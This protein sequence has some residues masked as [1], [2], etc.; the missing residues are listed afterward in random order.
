M[1]IYGEKEERRVNVDIES[2]TLSSAGQGI[3]VFRQF[4]ILILN[5]EAEILNGIGRH[6]WALKLPLAAANSFKRSANEWALRDAL[7]CRPQPMNFFTGEREAIEA[8]SEQSRN[9]RG[10]RLPIPCPGDMNVRSLNPK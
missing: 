8:I 1:V 6:E 7:A 10:V 3:K 5:I 4:A 2:I 9:W